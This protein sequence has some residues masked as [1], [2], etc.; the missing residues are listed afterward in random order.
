MLNKEKNQS[1]KGRGGYRGIFA[2]PCLRLS[3]PGMVLLSGGSFSELSRY[4]VK[5]LL[6]SLCF[7]PLASTTQNASLE[8]EKEV[9]PDILLP[10]LWERL[11][12]WTDLCLKRA[13]RLWCEKRHR[14]ANACNSWLAEGNRNW[15]ALNWNFRACGWC[16]GFTI[17]FWKHLLCRLL[18][19][20]SVSYPI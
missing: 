9:N 11:W 17:V 10:Y 6:N 7:L 16:L 18:F 3:V 14:S 8:V 15:I 1:Q 13:L 12:G 4:L 19:V 5:W 2:I 20:P